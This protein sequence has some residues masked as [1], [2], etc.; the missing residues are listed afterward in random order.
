MDRIE[1]A[2]G[3]NNL[4]DT[5]P[6]PVPVGAAGTTAGGTTAYFPATN[7]VAPFSNYSPNGFN[8]RFVYGRISFKF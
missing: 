6:T 4:F 3:A 5:Y 8:G 7:Y 2:V 1:L